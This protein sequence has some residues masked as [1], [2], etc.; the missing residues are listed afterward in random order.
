MSECKICRDH[1]YPGIMIAWDNN[2]KT[3]TGK[4]VPLEQDKITPHK[5]YEPNGNGNGSNTTKQQEPLNSNN[6]TT[7]ES[8]TEEFQTMVKHMV[9]YLQQQASK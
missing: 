8:L 6:Y 2:V 9:E 4:F 1:G 5:H 7:L 3:K